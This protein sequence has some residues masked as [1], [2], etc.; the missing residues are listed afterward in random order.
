M[1]KLSNTSPGFC[2]FSDTSQSWPSRGSSDTC[3]IWATSLCFC[4]LSDACSKAGCASSGCCVLTPLCPQTS[5]L[6]LMPVVI[7]PEE[8]VQR[9]CE[10]FQD[11]KSVQ[12][13]LL[14]DLCNHDPNVVPD[15]LQPSHSAAWL[16]N[17]LSNFRLKSIDSSEI[18][19][20]RADDNDTED[21]WV[22]SAITLYKGTRLM[23][24]KYI[25]VLVLWTVWCRYR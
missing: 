2:V 6:P 23:K 22:Q 9:L 3:C 21:D 4:T 8:G 13:R 15:F 16:H 19:R 5:V 25:C 20:L 18:T 14:L 1:S 11:F 12:L 17:L 7:V 24:N 10:I